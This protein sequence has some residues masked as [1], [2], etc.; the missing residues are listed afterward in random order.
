MPNLYEL[1]KG[2]ASRLANHTTVEAREN[3]LKLIF[4][5]ID[6]LVEIPGNIPITESQIKL[7]LRYLRDELKALGFTSKDIVV[8]ESTRPS[9]EGL[10]ELAKSLSICN[11]EALDLIS[12][13]ASRTKENK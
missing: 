13:M 6:K 8:H 12:M 10:E 3:E 1:A 4:R 5:E 9:L 11:D 2:Y 7:L